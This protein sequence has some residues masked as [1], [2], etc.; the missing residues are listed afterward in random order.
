NNWENFS[1]DMEPR[2]GNHDTTA[3]TIVNGCTLPAGQTVQQDTDGVVD[4]LFNHP[5][6]PPFIALRLIR[7]FVMSNPAPA[8]V[9]RIATVFANNGSGV[10][11]D[12][13]ATIQ[14]ILLDP[15]AR[16]DV[17]A[18]NSGRLREPIA[19]TISMI[20]ALN[21]QVSP[22]NGMAYVYDNLSQS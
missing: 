20:R 19:H 3:K 4:C 12:L 16:N 18:V 8:Y 9:Q 13:K 1:A 7:A 10:R 21:G 11:G 17:P 22:T 2:Q 5:N 14:A 15:D 6:L